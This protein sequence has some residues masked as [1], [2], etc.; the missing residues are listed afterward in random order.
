MGSSFPRIKFGICPVCGGT[1]GD[2][3]DAGG[4]DVPARDV[5]GN[6]C[7]LE[8]YQGRLMCHLCIQKFKDDDQG[9]IEAEKHKEAER[10]RAKA[11]FNKEV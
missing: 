4:A 1:C 5:I 11:G 2:D 9:L 7:E 6:G 8:Y 10:F 3:P